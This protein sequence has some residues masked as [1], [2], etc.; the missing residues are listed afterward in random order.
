MMTAGFHSLRMFRFDEANE[1]RF[2]RRGLERTIPLLRV[3][4]VIGALAFLGYG[5][6]DAL[7]VGRNGE[8]RQPHG[9]P[10]RQRRDS[11]FGRHAPVAAGRVPGRAPRRID[12]RGG[13][14]MQTWLLHG[15]GRTQ[16]D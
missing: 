9:E 3:A 4:S 16:G 7:I 2:A 10:W 11:D 5:G 1:A 13:G 14:P 15:H 12:V 6:W 8:P